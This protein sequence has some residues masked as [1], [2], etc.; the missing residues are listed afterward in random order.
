M[1]EEFGGGAKWLA[2]VAG[3]LFYEI[4]PGVVSGVFVFVAGVTQANNKLYAGVWRFHGSVNES[5]VTGWWR[6]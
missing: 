6:G 2:Q 3:E 5:A 4:L 1:A